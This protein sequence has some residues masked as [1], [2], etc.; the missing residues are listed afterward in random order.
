MVSVIIPLYNKASYVAKALDSVL[1]QTYTDYECII[2]NDGST[3]NSL[4]VVEDWLEVKGKSEELRTRYRLITQ[5]NAG[6]SAARNRGIAEAKG[7]YI[8]FLDADDWWAPTFLEEMMHLIEEYPDAGLYAGNY[9][10]YKPGKTHI[11]VS[12]ICDVAGIMQVAEGW[13]GYINY[14]KSYFLGS[15][16]P[17]TSIS[18]MIPK[19]VLDDTGGFPEGIR[20]GEDFLTWSRIAMQYPVAF[21]NR[22]LAYYNNDVPASARATRNLHAPEYHM[23][24]NLDGT[25]DAEHPVNDGEN[26]LMTV[27]CGDWRLLFDKL[28]VTGLM[29]YWMDHQYHDM[30]AAELKKVDWNALSIWPQTAH[31]QRLYALP[32]WLL[33]L[34]KTMLTIG[35]WIKCKM[36]NAACKMINGIKCRV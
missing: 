30:A 26:R 18:V 25:E 29:S 9:I 13:S 17:V 33:R 2:V 3:D 12:S 6:V 8:A 28:R 23:L 7:K 20:L 1:A 19:Q 14:P 5:T 11:A 36:Q 15:A 16:M 34:R 24:W 22:P 35:Y 31:Y 21:V 10:Y 27:N 32:L 4:Q